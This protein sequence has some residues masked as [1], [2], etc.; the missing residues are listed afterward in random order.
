VLDV[1]VAERG[2]QRGL[3]AWLRD[4][5]V[6]EQDEGESDEED[7]DEEDRGSDER[8]GPGSDAARGVRDG[9]GGHPSVMSRLR[10]ER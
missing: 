8:G 2:V 5:L 9:H 6:P 1:E 4:V 10:R 3:Q 7:P